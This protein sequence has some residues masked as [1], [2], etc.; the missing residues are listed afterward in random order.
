MKIVQF[1]LFFALFGSATVVTAQIENP[2]DDNLFRE[3][4]ITEIK[5]TM[6]A[7]DKATLLAEENRYADIYFPA[8]L[9][10][11]NSQLNN[12]EVLNVGIRLRGNTARQHDKRSF[13]IDFREYGGL[14]FEGHKKINLKP[15]VND[16]TLVRELLSMHLYR[17]MGVPALRVSPTSV[18][19]NEEYMGAYLMT[20]QVDD[21]FVDRRFGHEEGFLYKCS[22][23]ASLTNNGQVFNESVYESEIN[24]ELDTRAEL[25]GFVTSLNNST[26]IG[27]TSV[28]RDVFDVDTYLRQLA[29][30]SMIGHWDGYSYNKNNFYLFYDAQTGLMNFIPYD[31]DNTWGIDWIGGNWAT[32]N[33]ESFYHPSDSRPLTKKLLGVPEY[34][35][36]YRRHLGYLRHAYFNATYL[37]ALFDQLEAL[38]GPKVQTDTYFD[39]AFGFNYSFFQSSYDNATGGHVKYGLRGYLSTR[40][41]N[42]SDYVLSSSSLDNEFAIYPNPSTNPQF[43]FSSP[44]ES[45]LRLSLYDINGKQV[46][47]NIERLGLSEWGVSLV[48]NSPGMYLI[49]YNDQVIKW[50][51]K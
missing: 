31:T 41:T 30:E 3:L 33:V 23:G 28:F 20:E 4:E 1:W 46:R 9:V 47:F 26:S 38:V 10:I 40:Y 34:K 29:V 42:T 36:A 49:R 39:D 45:D 24:E 21:E 17:K 22:Y 6:L 7:Q 5:V 15:N 50:M 2:G 51:Y 27:L 8:D 44:I 16:P 43:I 48:E 11:K 19:I 37:H 35:E 18:Y 25:D 13:K 14:K 32:Y 12:V